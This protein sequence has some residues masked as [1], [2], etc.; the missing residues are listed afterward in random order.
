M[1]GGQC[2]LLAAEG[3]VLA[4]WSNGAATGLVLLSA[5]GGL[6]PVARFQ[7]EGRPLGARL[8]GSYAYVG[9]RLL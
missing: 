1:G 8:E 7:I 2:Q 3:R 9:S 4:I 5:D 6:R